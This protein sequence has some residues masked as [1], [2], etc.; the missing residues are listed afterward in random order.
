MKGFTK[1][2]IAVVF[3]GTFLGLDLFSHRV[4]A[5]QQL[6]PESVEFFE[7]K[8]RP[9]L[10]SNCYGCHSAN[11]K[12]LQGG[13]QLDT[14]EGMLKGGNSGQP[15]ITPGDPDSSLLI[16]AIRYNDSKL[17]MPPTGQLSAEQ[18]KD[19]EAWVK[20]GAPDPRWQSATS[21]PL[22]A[23]YNFDEARKFWSFQPISNPPAPKV[24]D[25]AWLRSDIDRFILAKLESKGIKP[26]RDAEKRTLIR[27]ATFD[28]T[29]LPP[30]PDEIDAFL[31]DTSP[32]AFEKVVDRLLASPQYGERWGRHWLDLVRY[33]DTAGCNS[34]FPIPAAYKYRN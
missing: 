4:S 13:L 5:Q 1:T 14:R 8:I 10:E 19:L 25:N 28:L 24:K 12:R 3:L 17:Q 31:R 23:A 2:A 18:I 26:V 6:S 30:T 29:G 33:A 32:K 20:M 11:S 22:A 15:S 27:R 9:V 21:Q 34:D 16:R 7:K